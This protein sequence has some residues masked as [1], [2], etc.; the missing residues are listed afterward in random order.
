MFPTLNGRL[1]EVI[2]NLDAEDATGNAELIKQI[3]GIL[4]GIK[5]KKE[6]GEKNPLTNLNKQKTHND[7]RLTMGE[8]IQMADLFIRLLSSRKTSKHITRLCKK[9]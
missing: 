9:Y 5:N 3:G 8:K 4:K 1:Q 6:E 2:A 7:L